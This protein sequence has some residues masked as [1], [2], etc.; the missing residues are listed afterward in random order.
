VAL[1]KDIDCRML[2]FTGS[3]AVRDVE[4]VVGDAKHGRSD[5]DFARCGVAAEDARHFAD[6]RGVS[7]RGTAEF[8]DV[9]YGRKRSHRR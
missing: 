4:Q 9:D 6:R 5:N 8:V 7:E 3:C 2:P 1:A